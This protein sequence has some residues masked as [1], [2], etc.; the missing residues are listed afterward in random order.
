[1]A[2]L[3]VTAYAM[4]I[5]AIAVT[6]TQITLPAG[7][8]AA[9]SKPAITIKNNS[10]NSLTISEPAINAA[11]ADLH[12]KEIQSGRTFIVDLKFPVGFQIQ[13]GQGVEATFKTTN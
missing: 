1:M 5:P 12:V 3:A 11:G 7:P 9:E 4:V 6:P 2:T 8:L 13:P 10:T